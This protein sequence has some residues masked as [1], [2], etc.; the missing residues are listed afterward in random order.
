MDSNIN[1]ISNN[2]KKSTRYIEKCLDVDEGSLDHI[3]SGPKPENVEI[4]NE[5]ER[6]NLYKE[7]N[8]FVRIKELDKN[9][10]NL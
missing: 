4:D 9:I 3:G 1:I 6:N 5:K 7:D 8:K 2:R 10:R